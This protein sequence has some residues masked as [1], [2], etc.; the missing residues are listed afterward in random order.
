[1]CW[2]AMAESRWGKRWGRVRGLHVVFS[3][4]STTAAA[5]TTTTTTST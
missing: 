1:M 4:P 2:G 3:T 5:D